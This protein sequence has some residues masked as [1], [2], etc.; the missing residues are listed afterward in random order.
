[1]FKI[2]AAA[3]N[4]QQS[5]EW[6]DAQMC[7]ST[8]GL[9]AFC[10]NEHSKS[11]GHKLISCVLNSVKL[12]CGSYTN[13]GT[14]Q[15]H[16]YWLRPPL[17]LPV[18]GLETCWLLKIMSLILGFIFLLYCCD[19]PH[20]TMSIFL[21]SL[22]FTPIQVTQLLITQHMLH[23]HNTCTCQ[24]VPTGARVCCLLHAISSV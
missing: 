7:D 4:L 15:M 22:L 16:L 6:S 10:C 2:L 5:A 13:G 8:G 24:Q 18:S 20:S 1:M 9:Y 3:K 23:T 11:K 17:L 21:A 14:A 19:G 12:G